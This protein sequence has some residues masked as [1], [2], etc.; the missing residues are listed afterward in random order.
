MLAGA[1]FED[2]SIHRHQTI[3]MMMCYLEIFM[4]RNDV[5]DTE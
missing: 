5:L 3:M 1:R 4:L 2:V